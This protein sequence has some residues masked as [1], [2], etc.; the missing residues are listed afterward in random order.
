[1]R[2]ALTSASEE[3]T[4]MGFRKQYVVGWGT[5][6]LINTGLAQGKGEGV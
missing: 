3:I 5:L 1:M 6:E 2:A 4:L